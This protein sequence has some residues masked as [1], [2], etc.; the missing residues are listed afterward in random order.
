MRSGGLPEYSPPHEYSDSRGRGLN[1]SL[2]GRPEGGPSPSQA[3]TGCEPGQQKGRGSLR[4]LPPAPQLGPD[5][6]AP[7]VA[8]PQPPKS[9]AIHP[10]ARGIQSL[11]PGSLEFLHCFLRNLEV[12]APATLLEDLRC[13]A[14]PPGGARSSGRQ[15][16]GT[17]EAE[18]P[19]PALELRIP[20]RTF[21]PRVLRKPSPRPP[22]W[23]NLESDLKR[24]S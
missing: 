8:L 11:G 6:P 3:G 16:R 5:S 23:R 13:P 12:Q 21:P 9:G 7:D 24:P 4:R 14:P 1:P 10:G 20:D 22:G 18:R 15:L 2:A 19:A 17:L